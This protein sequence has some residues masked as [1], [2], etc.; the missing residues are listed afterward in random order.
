MFWRWSR[1]LVLPVVVDAVGWEAVLHISGVSCSGSCV[2]KQ[3]LDPS[4]H[5]G[6]EL[7]GDAGP[8]IWICEEQEGIEGRCQVLHVCFLSRAPPL[9]RSR[10]MKQQ[11][12]CMPYTLMLNL[13]AA[14]DERNHSRS[15][16]LADWRDDCPWRGCWLG[17]LSQ[18]WN[19]SR[20]IKTGH[21]APLVLT[22]PSCTSW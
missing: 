16:G 11:P 13:R 3:G 15:T 19:G 7:V 1:S 20:H 18:F 9:L 22:F 6:P 21:H 14:F 8:H 17:L 10:Q 12:W 5:H 4:H 2:A